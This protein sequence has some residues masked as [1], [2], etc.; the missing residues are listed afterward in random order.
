M[1]NVFE[2]KAAIVTGASSGIGRMIAQN[3]GAAGMDLWLVGRSGEQLQV[4]AKAIKDAGGPDPHCVPLELSKAGALAE[5][6]TEA[7][8]MHPYL[9]AVINNAG[10]MYPEPI[11]DA[12][13]ARWHEMF[14]INLLTPM[15]S[16]R[17]AVREMRKHG[18]PG[19][20]INVS[21][22]AGRDDIYGAYGVTKSALNHMGSVL[23]HELEGDNI[24]V[25][26]IVPGGFTTN[27]S[28]GFTPELLEQLQ[29]KMAQSN[30]DP[31]G[32]DA[33]KYLSDPIHIANMVNHILQLPIELNIEQLT[34][35]PAINTT[36]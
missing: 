22:I 23:R 33:R 20:L 25:C 26:T 35:R 11:I 29:K 34:I 32:P 17:A 18:K 15:E 5:L 28:R 10:V 12:D 6:V 1:T 19:H 3:L 16:C 31:T 27:L 24:R 36:I 7:G 4:T 2:G 13:P 8:S 9:F 30:F 14:A 21:S